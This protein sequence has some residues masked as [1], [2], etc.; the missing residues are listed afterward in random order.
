MGNGEGIRIDFLAHGGE[1][2]GTLDSGKRVFVPDTAPGDL[3]EIEVRERR[4]R[5][6]RGRVVRLLEPGPER[7]S[8]P[9][10]HASACGGC[11]LQHLSAAGQTTAK[12]RIFYEALARLGGIPRDSLPEARPILASPEAFRYRI[13]CRLQ[14][15]SEGLGYHRR[16]T[17]ELVPIESCHLL[18]PP[19]E[20]LALRVRDR[21]REAPIHHLAAVE[22]CIGTDG[23][24]ALALEPDAGAPPRWAQGA[25]RLLE[26]EGLR[27]V[28]VLPARRARRSAAPRV[29]G[30]PV[31]VR[32]APSAPGVP[33]FLRPDVF[34][35]ANAEANEK[36]VQAAID[37]LAPGEGE[38]VL[39]L[40]AG[41]GNF[42]F[43]LAS[44]GARVTA[45]EVEGAALELARRAAN[46]PLRERIRFRSGLA[47]RVVE[48]LAEAGPRFDLV[49][50]DPPRTGAKEIVPGLLRLRPRRIAYVSCDPATL[51]RDLRLLVE[52]GYRPRLAQPFDLFPQTFHVEALVVL[53]R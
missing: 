22:L 51:A 8:P 2:V 10:P 25:E 24:G 1:G 3:V 47:H 31:V 52:G 42:T 20:A 14:V 27:G 19:L 43:A 7:V 6:E 26:V 32:E 48:E 36:L 28:V 15:G 33:L 4:P 39:E 50:L 29:L 41:S 12:E 49:L 21:L 44:R 38:E 18:A 30:D 5:Y 11:Q 53:E 35:Q 13:R 9:C 34:A 16:G 45:V 17:R 46:A 23:R 37:A 40:Y